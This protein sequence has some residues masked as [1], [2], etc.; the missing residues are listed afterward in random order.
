MAVKKAEV[1]EVVPQ[2]PRAPKI[3]DSVLYHKSIQ[4]QTGS[5]FESYPALVTGFPKN[6]NF[7]AKDMAVH[8]AIFGQPG[9][10]FDHKNEVMFSAIPTHGRWSHKEE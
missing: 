4:T 3:G 1:K 10:P 9:S 6:G 8:I 7:Q 2:I 5:R